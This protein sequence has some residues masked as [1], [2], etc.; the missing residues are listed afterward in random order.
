MIISQQ[1]EY[2][3]WCGKFWCCT[4]SAICEVKSLPKLLKSLIGQVFSQPVL[5]F[6]CDCFFQ[7]IGYT[8]RYFRN[9]AGVLFVFLIKL[10]SEEHTSEL[11][12]RFDLVCRLLLEKK[13]CLIHAVRTLRLHVL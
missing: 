10:R 3:L 6:G 5:T 7:C 2:I 13:K 8:F 1:K 11:Q 12:S 9:V 4:K